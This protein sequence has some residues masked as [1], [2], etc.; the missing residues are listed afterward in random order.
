[1]LPPI[2]SLPRIKLKEFFDQIWPIKATRRHV[3]YKDAALIAAKLSGRFQKNPVLSP[4]DAN[5]EN[6]NGYSQ[7]GANILAKVSRYFPA[8]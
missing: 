1:M 6:D 8:A 7:L 2:Q 5:C 3:H 4:Y